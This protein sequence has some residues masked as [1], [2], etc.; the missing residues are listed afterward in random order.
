MSRMTLAQCADALAVLLDRNAT[1]N[2][3]R[4]ELTFASHGE[5]MTAMRRAR[6]ALRTMREVEAG[7]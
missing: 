2:G 7:V 6:D 1:Y 3:S 4:I 5:A